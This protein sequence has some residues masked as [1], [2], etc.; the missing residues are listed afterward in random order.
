MQA[1][2]VDKNALLHELS[3]LR[4][5][6]D[7]LERQISLVSLSFFTFVYSPCHTITYIS[8]TRPHSGLVVGRPA[9]Q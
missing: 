5:E 6:K 9:D 2:H 8:L 7:K 3:A 4:V 1:D